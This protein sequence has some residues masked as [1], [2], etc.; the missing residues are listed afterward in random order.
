MNFM[1]R[2]YRESGFD[3]WDGLFLS[4]CWYHDNLLVNKEKIERIRKI[5]G[6]SITHP[7]KRVGL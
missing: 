3:H 7:L 4:L 6:K 2:Y 1:Y 5:M